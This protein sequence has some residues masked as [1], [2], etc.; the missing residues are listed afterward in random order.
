M[1][2]TVG[3]PHDRFKAYVTHH[4]V[5]HKPHAAATPY[6]F[7]VQGAR[8]REVQVVIGFYE[9]R[10]YDEGVHGQRLFRVNQGQHLC[11]Q[12]TQR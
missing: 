12:R 9:V 4:T 8:F 3:T 11:T 2:T 6:R 10:W 5:H 1:T 7:A